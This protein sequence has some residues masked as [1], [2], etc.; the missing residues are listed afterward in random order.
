[1]AVLR[2]ILSPDGAAVPIALVVLLGT[3]AAR[4]TSFG[5]LFIILWVPVVIPFGIWAVVMFQKTFGGASKVRRRLGEVPLRYRVTHLL[6]CVSVLVIGLMIPDGGDNGPIP[7]ALARMLG[8]TDSADLTGAPAAVSAVGEA[9]AG[10]ILVILVAPTVLTVTYV[11]DSRAPG[12][13]AGPVTSL[14]RLEER[15]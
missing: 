4:C 12:E 8:A 11:R 1:V 10:L 6:W 2:R 7:S 3:T 15:S 13:G 14:P 9:L 5:W